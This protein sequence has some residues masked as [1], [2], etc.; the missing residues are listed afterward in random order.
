MHLNQYAAKQPPISC[1][2]R[3]GVGLL[4]ASCFCQSVFATNGYSPTGFG[5]TNKGMVG[6]GVALPQDS[7]AAATNPA[8]MGLLGNRT[9]VGAALFYPSDRG[10]TADGDE[11]SPIRGGEYTSEND[12]FLVP[13]F[14]WNKPLT[15]HSALGISIGG[16]GGMNTE[17]DDAVF[18]NF[19]NPYAPPASSPTGVDFAQLFIGVTYAYELSPDQ[20]LGVMPIAAVQRFKAEGLEPFDALSTSPG[21]VSNNGYDMSYG[22][23]IRFG[24]LGKLND[25]LSLGASY[26]SRLYMSEFEDYEG[27]FAEQGDFDT[28]ST[29]VVGLAYSATPEVTLVLDYQRINYGEVKSLSNGNDLDISNPD[30]HL[31]ADDGLGFGWDDMDIIKLGIQWEYD[32]KWTFRAG[33]SHASELFEGTQ[34][35]FNILAPATIRDH[36]SL[37]STYKY[38]DTNQVNMSLTRAFKEEVEG[39]SVFTGSQTG[40]VEME[41]WELEL[42][43]AHMF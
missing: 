40:S 23:G 5:T 33:Y 16:N 38:S 17:Y 10:F 30:Y 28:P 13:H 26:Q 35:L 27:L 8:G 22:Y 42:S 3:I 6:A 2:I 21:K 12:L 39:T 14:G 25:R 7:L 19:N 11:T 41:Q 36:I 29:W 4:A 9:D 24:W 37:G 31:G 15:E 20:W 34:A 1:F 43:W 18:T 32:P